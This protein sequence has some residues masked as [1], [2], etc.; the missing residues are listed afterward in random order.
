MS[1]ERG[2]ADAPLE[3]RLKAA[4]RRAVDR[5]ERDRQERSERDGQGHDGHRGPRRARER[6]ERGQATRA[7]DEERD[8]DDHRHVRV[9][10]ALHPDALGDADETHERAVEVATEERGLEEEAHRRHA[11]EEER[12]REREPDVARG[13]PRPED[14]KRGPRDHPEQRTERRERQ[15]PWKDDRQERDH[16]Q[17]ERPVER[18]SAGCEQ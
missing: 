4:I 7:L 17:A 16:R 13:R 3:E 11:E 9:R 14:L 15:A 5:G 6:S 18:S 10:S 12:D 1:R 8:G 2:L